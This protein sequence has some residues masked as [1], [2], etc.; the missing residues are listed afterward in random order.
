MR[1]LYAILDTEYVATDDL[2]PRCQQ[3]LEHGCQ[4]IQYRDKRA[5]AQQR[6]QRATPLAAAC[7]DAGTRLI[8]NDDVTLANALNCGVHVGAD[9]ASVSNARALLGNSAVVGASCYNQFALAEQ[10]AADGASY[11]AFGAFFNSSTKPNAVAASIDLLHKASTLS[12]PTVA[13]G[14][15]T[16]DNS[17]PIVAAGADMLA[18]ISD[19][20]QA[21]DLAAQIQRFQKLF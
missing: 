1:G 14:G 18:V 5:S 12:V 10:A 16:A 15:L 6:H 7:A 11:V 3:L 4:I 13:I 20:W 21:D 19:L 8:I 2:L 9:D 17:A